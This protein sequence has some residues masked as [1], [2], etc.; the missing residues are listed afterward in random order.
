MRKKI[1]SWLIASSCI[2]F[3]MAVSIPGPSTA[4]EAIKLRLSNALAPGTFQNKV[5]LPAFAKEVKDK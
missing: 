3:V 4:A 1:L 2:V 5:L